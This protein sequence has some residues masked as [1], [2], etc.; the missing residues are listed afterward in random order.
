[1]RVRLFS[2]STLCGVALSLSCSSI[3]QLAMTIAHPMPYP[4]PSNF[5]FGVCPSAQQ[6][7]PPGC[8]TAVSLAASVKIICS[9]G[10]GCA[11][12]CESSQLVSQAFV[13]YEARLSG[14]AS[15]A[16]NSANN[17]AGP[18]KSSLSSPSSPSSPS[19]W[20]LYDYNC[21]QHDIPLQCVGANA[22]IEACKAVC[23]DG[24]DCGGFLYYSK[25][26]PP[27]FALKNQ[28]CFSGIGPLP[29]SD[30][31]DVLYVM[32]E[33]PP[34][35]SSG[36]S[37]A[38]V[39]VCLTGDGSEVLDSSTDE[40]YTLTVTPA[41]AATRARVS[42]ATPAAGSASATV[43][44][45]SIFGAM[46]GL[47]SLTQLVDVRVGSTGQKTIPSAPVVVSDAPRWSYRGLLIDTG[48]HFLPLNHLK[49]VVE[50]A[51]ATKLNVIHWHAVDSTS[52]ATCSAKYPT[53]CTEGNVHKHEMHKFVAFVS[54]TLD[55][56]AMCVCVCVWVGVPPPL[57]LLCVCVWQIPRRP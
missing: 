29:Q 3:S 2:P 6:S 9:D 27:S 8:T 20:R 15:R 33:Q 53:L 39:E 26:T 51:S 16:R 14:T 19:W 56:R 57:W 31:G 37:L 1:M 4:L 47:E 54:E 52:F 22:T 5:S 11:K 34:L 49:H 36:G 17:V 18:S 43:T 35:P 32:H 40:S 50:A 28:T 10:P 48:R 21:D 25:Q 45:P 44:A 41:T 7:P 13:R 23:A 24:P 30:D 55:T 12:S 42:A 46:H 38:T